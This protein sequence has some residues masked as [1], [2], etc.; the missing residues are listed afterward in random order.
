MS[1]RIDYWV[2]DLSECRVVNYCDSGK[3]VIEDMNQTLTE[4][5]PEDFCWRPV[6]SWEDFQG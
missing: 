3:I 1:L 2:K 6:W 4:A 5:A